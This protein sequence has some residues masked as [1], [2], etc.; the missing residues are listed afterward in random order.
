MKKLLLLLFV[1]SLA[2]VSCTDNTEEYEQQYQTQAT[3]KDAETTPNS[4]GGSTV[5][6][7]ED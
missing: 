1:C 3:E 2:F 5:D 4:D 7:D 6:E